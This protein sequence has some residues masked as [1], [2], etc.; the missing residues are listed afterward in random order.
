M[1]DDELL[2]GML[3]LKT[4]PPEPFVPAHVYD[5]DI[6]ALEDEIERLRHIRH[7]D[8]MR[9]RRLTRLR[10]HLTEQAETI[11]ALKL[12]LCGYKAEYADN[13]AWIDEAKKT[14][15][16]QAKTITRLRKVL[17]EIAKKRG[18]FNMDPLIH[19]SNAVDDMAALAIIALAEG[20]KYGPYK[21]DEP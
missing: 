6:K 15:A 4:V 3:R 18:R 9:K 11:N 2:D 16:E 19:A 8:A 10:K 12:E 13:T 7:R 21:T 1:V 20:E 17:T 14:M 5:R